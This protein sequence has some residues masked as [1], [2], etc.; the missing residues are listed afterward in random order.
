[1]VREWPLYRR[2]DPCR[3][4]VTWRTVAWLVC[5]SNLL[6][7]EKGT[8]TEVLLLSKKLKVEDVSC[9]QRRLVNFGFPSRFLYLFTKTE[10]KEKHTKMWKK[11]PF[12]DLLWILE[13]KQFLNFLFV[14][15]KEDL[16][17]FLEC[18]AS[19]NAFH[20]PEFTVRKRVKR[21]TLQTGGGNL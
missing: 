3:S 19:P 21:F 18:T 10:G 12:Y 8:K 16:V 13:K 7:K 15:W 17:F 2:N 20:Q 6:N 5:L 11:I 9:D 4:R 1:M 14:W